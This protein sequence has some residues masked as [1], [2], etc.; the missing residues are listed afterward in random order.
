MGGLDS[1]RR[2]GNHARV[3]DYEASVRTVDDGSIEEPGPL[4]VEFRNSRT[5]KCQE[6]SMDEF[7]GGHL[8]HLA[9]AG[10]VHNDLFREAA[11]LG[12]TL[13]RVEVSADGGFHG[14]PCTTAGIQYTIHVEGQASRSALDALVARVER[15]AEVPSAIRLGGEVRLTR[16]SVVSTLD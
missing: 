1:R 12:I 4:V 3:G 15:I 2:L 10:C 16:A 8:L 6:F 13:T 14:D 5:G 11:V 9:V 7:T